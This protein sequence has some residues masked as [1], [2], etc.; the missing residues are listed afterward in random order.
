MQRIEAQSP[1]A[2]RA[3]TLV[4]ALQQQL[5]NRMEQISQ[6]AGTNSMFE[7][8]E[9]FRAEGQHGGGVRY[10]AKDEAVFNRGSV[11]VSQV[12]YEEDAMR[13][14]GSATALSSIIHPQNP[15]A[16]SVHL[17]V[18][19]TELKNGQAYWRIMADLNPVVEHSPATEQF[20]RCLQDAAPEQFAE[21]CAQG[22]RYFFIPV[23]NRHRGVCHFYLENYRTADAQADYDLAERVI[24]RIID[25]YA[26]ILSQAID[27][28]PSPS[29]EDFQKQLAYH[30]LYF[31]QVLTLDRGTTS[32][33]LVHDQNDIGTLGSLPARIDK[34]LLQRWLPNM[35]KPQNELLERLIACVPNAQHDSVGSTIDVAEKQALAAAIRQHYQK[36]PKALNLQASADSIPTT[37]ANHR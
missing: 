32:G 19:W 15:L 36:H 13:S 28:N 4:S 12:Q 24:S 6:A 34:A 5:V 7:P 23:L 26:D 37:V 9:W 35:P 10:V 2:R 30:T 25:S 21:A 29:T 14:L 22:N 11:N 31:L 18:S 3:Y 20:H 27:D 33:L 8:V 1:S 17:H 16:P